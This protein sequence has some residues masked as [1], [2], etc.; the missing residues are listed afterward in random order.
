MGVCKGKQEL[1]GIAGVIW[2]QCL[3]KRIVVWNLAS[4]LYLYIT[5]NKTTGIKLVVQ[6]HV[7]YNVFLF[8]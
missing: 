4:N 1:M 3:E 8:Q 5:E 7:E 6:P 2:I